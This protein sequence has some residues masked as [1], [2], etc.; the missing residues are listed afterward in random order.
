M[1]PKITSGTGSSCSVHTVS[2]LRLEHN[3]LIHFTWAQVIEKDG[4]PTKAQWMP[5]WRSVCRLLGA[6]CAFGAQYGEKGM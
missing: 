4:L 1:W 5:T 6:G 3:G 2:Q